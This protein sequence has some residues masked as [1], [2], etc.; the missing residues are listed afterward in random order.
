[1]Y[2]ICI[3]MCITISITISISIIIMGVYYFWF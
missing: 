2:N 1:M 3:K